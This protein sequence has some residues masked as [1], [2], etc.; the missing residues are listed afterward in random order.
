[1]KIP[2]PLLSLAAAF[3]ALVAFGGIAPAHAR[4]D[5]SF[6]FFYDSLDPYGEW[7][8]V[9]DYGYVW[10]PTSVDENW[11]PYTDGYWAYTDA[12]WTWVS[13]EDYG[14]IVYHYGRWTRIPG[15]GWV[16]VP[17]ET[18]APAWVSWRTSDDYVGWAPLP[19]EAHWR[20]GVGFGGW[21]DARFDIGPRFYSFVGVGDFGA[22]VLGPVIVNR[23][24]NVTIINRTTNI[25][26][27][28][29]N[30]S[31]VYTGG[32]RYSVMAA[33]S[34]RPI[35]TLK[36]VR[37]TDV[38]GIKAGGGKILSRQSG[39]QLMVIA[40]KVSATGAGGTKPAPAKVA[41]TLTGVKADH[42]WTGVPD[43][44]SAKLHAQFKSQAAAAGSSAKPVSAA[45]I[46]V[47]TDKVK[48]QPVANSAD[49]SGV[50]PKNPKSKGGKAKLTDAE[51]LNAPA[52]D[53]TGAATD[54]ITPAA[55]PKGAK[56]KGKK[57]RA[58]ATDT[59]AATAGEGETPEP[60]ASKKNRAATEESFTG[61]TEQAGPAETPAKKGR[62][63][64]RAAT[65]DSFLGTQEDAATPRAKVR[66]SDDFPAGD[67]TP[68][69][70]KHAASDLKPFDAEESAPKEPKSYDSGP[71]AGG[72]FGAG[73]PRPEKVKGKGKK[74]KNVD[75]YGNPLAP[76]Q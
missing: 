27:I 49:V 76:G 13:Y 28:T 8:D 25:T 11:A 52:T 65:E 2:K 59:G 30:N 22:T 21:V 68:K 26:N 46:K 14:G 16:W 1:M 5:V 18:W 10:H 71:G 56:G 4:A 42:G 43:A 58:I 40:P 29:V 17:G 51:L 54:T 55:T 3:V 12:G 45:D 39:N 41:R 57:G 72:D 67:A 50:A 15:E 44:D 63:K 9:P 64:G 24:Q 36:L 35:P 20:V 62:K 37:Q 73:A 34:T 74:S 6:G 33:R 75:Q 19:P 31:T 48:A 38:S 69:R 66:E 53:T 60:K 70:P 23:E 32:P 7:V 61:T 47:V